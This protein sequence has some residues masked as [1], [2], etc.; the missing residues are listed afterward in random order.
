MLAIPTLYVILVL[1][2]TEAVEEL[3]FMTQRL[4]AR[5]HATHNVFTSVKFGGVE[6]RIWAS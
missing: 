3:V 5:L 1:S 4:H 2:V 6:L